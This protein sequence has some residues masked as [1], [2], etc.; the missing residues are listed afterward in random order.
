MNTR[1]GIL[2]ASAFALS[3]SLSACGD[4]EPNIDP[5]TCPVGEHLSDGECVH[6]E[7]EGA[8][9]TYSGETGPESWG[10]LSEE[11]ATCG[12]GVE[13]SPIDINSEIGASPVESLTMNYADST[14]NVLNNGH[15]V[16][17]NYAPGSDIALNGVTY[18]LKQFHFHSNSEHTVDGQAFPLEM[19]LV[20]QATDGSLAVLGVFFEDGAENE[21]LAG[22]FEN[23]PAD[24]QEATLVDGLTVNASEFIPADGDA[25]TYAGSLTTP[26]CSEGVAWTVMATPL[27]ASTE[28]LSAFSD[29]FDHNYRPTQPLGA[30]EVANG[31]P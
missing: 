9:W 13:Q 26:P 6:D 15:T 5:T 18:E 12:T 11:W 25:W 2:L 20:H 21:A 27:E 14:L 16:Q 1:S 7:T 17:V 10:E 31:A 23:L 22:V 3:A 30:R 28:Q 29:I 8:H 4:D 19:H 24:E